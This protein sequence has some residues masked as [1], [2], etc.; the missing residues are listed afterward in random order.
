MERVAAQGGIVLLQLQFFG[1]ELLVARGGVAGGGFAF[2]ARLSA[3]D[4][5]DFARH[6]YSFS[7]GFS[8][9]SSSS[10]T[11]VTPTASTVPRAPRRRWRSAPS[12]SSCAWAW[13][14]KRV[15]GMAS[16]RLLGMGLPVN[17]Q[18]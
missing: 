11:S 16:R 2:F 7:L 12:R 14:V 15:Q 8:S 9:G 3:F 17:S 5:D 13:T 4:S 1:F 10:S 6:G 18:M